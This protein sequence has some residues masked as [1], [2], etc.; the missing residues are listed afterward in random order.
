M[1]QTKT[2]RICTT[3]NS[4]SNQGVVK[5]EVPE[6]EEVSI[7]CVVNLTSK[8]FN[9]FFNPLLPGEGLLYIDSEE[10]FHFDV[11]DL[12][13]LVVICPDG[14]DFSINNSGELIFLKE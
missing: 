9:E 1:S 4:Q 3:L 12:G 8:I 14:Y 13:E 6:F 7:K 10:D 5:S 2:I 11:N